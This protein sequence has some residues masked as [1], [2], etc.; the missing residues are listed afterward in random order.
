MSGGKNGHTLRSLIDGGCGI[1]VGGCK[2]YQKLIVARVGE[3]E[4]VGGVG[5]DWKF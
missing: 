2:K 1:V 4:M 3:V 5:K